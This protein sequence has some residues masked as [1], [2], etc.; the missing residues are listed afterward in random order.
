MVDLIG[1]TR[2]VYSLFFT[3]VTLVILLEWYYS[4]SLVEL[5]ATRISYSIVYFLG[6]LT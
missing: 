6:Q 4:K 3:S 5:S 2:M 1:I